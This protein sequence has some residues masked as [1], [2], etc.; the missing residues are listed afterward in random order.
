MKKTCLIIALLTSCLAGFPSHC[1]ACTKEDNV[2]KIAV[3]LQT[4]DDKNHYERGFH[5][6]VIAN[7]YIRLSQLEIICPDEGA[8]SVQLFNSRNKMC[9]HAGFDSAETPVEVIDVPK[10]S[11]TYRIIIVTDKSYSEGSFTK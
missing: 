8:V 5:N 2:D 4:V 10:Q 7:Y 3:D 11:G 1:L 9:G 6:G